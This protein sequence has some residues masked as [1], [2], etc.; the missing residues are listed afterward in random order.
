MQSND[1]HDTGFRMQPCAWTSG[2][3]ADNGQYGNSGR[4]GLT[5]ADAQEIVQDVSSFLSLLAEWDREARAAASE[6]SAPAMRSEAG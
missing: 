1:N 5:P 3:S 4:K 6:A 2:D